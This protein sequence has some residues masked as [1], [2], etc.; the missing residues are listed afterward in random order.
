MLS[1]LFVDD[2]WGAPIQM[3]DSR[4]QTTPL[5]TPDD[6]SGQHQRGR[7]NV[8]VQE[9]V[10]RSG[11]NHHSEVAPSTARFREDQEPR[12]TGSGRR[13]PVMEQR[14]VRR[15]PSTILTPSFQDMI[16]RL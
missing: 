9:R 7:A 13:Q 6:V 15:R 12:T 1:C 8:R 16:S 10:T 5:R 4:R 3:A 2:C 14:I 11:G